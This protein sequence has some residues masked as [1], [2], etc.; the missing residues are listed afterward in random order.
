MKISLIITVYNEEKIIQETIS[1]VISY[2]DGLYGY[3]YELILVNDG[4]TDNTGKTIAEAVKRHPGKIMQVDHPYNMGRGQGMRSGFQKA[5]GDYVIT[6]DADLSYSPGHIGKLIDALVSQSVDIVCASPYMKGGIVENVPASRLLYS[7]LGNWLLSM[8][9]P[10]KLSTYTSIVRGYRREALDRL[11]L[12]SR[13]KEIHIE[14]LDKAYYLG[15]SIC[16]IPASLIW[17]KEHRIGGTAERKPKFNLFKIIH[18]HIVLAIFA[19]PGIIFAFPGVAL[20]SIGAYLTALFAHSFLKLFFGFYQQYAFNTA[21]SMA[22][23]EFYSQSQYSFMF[24]S[25]C[26]ILGIQFFIMYF[27]AIQ[28]KKYFEENFRMLS[29]IN[30]QLKAKK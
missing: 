21:L 28:N 23:R 9:H 26:L 30:S 29:R 11:E 8:V 25:F 3:Q 13:G 20:F 19:R 4:S 1:K 15:L 2:M 5:T 18:S 17:H 10:V 6:L 27:L 22:S 7:K 24:A 16:E 14:I 12:S